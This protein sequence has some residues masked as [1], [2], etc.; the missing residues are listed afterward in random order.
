VR[1][2]LGSTAGAG[3][4]VAVTG[5]GARVIMSSGSW[6]HRYV[7]SKVF[8]VWP[9]RARVR[10]GLCVLWGVTTRC[11]VLRVVQESDLQQGGSRREED[12]AAADGEVGG[13]K[14]LGG[15]PG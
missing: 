15:E 2:F 9:L 1:I 5:T 13:W 4:V 6:R 3:A 14:L 7:S 11:V 12:G 10:L 8:R